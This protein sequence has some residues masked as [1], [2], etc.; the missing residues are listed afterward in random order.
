MKTLSLFYLCAICLH[1]GSGYVIAFVQNC[2]ALP[3]PGPWAFN[4]NITILPEAWSKLYVMRGD[5]I[6]QSGK[7]YAEIINSG[8]GLIAKHHFEKEKIGTMDF[9]NPWPLFLN[10]P[11]PEGQPVFSDFRNTFDLTNHLAPEKMFG[12]TT[13]LIVPKFSNTPPTVM[14]L[15]QIYG[16]YLGTN[17]YKVDENHCWILLKRI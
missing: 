5:A 8:I 14:A 9:V 7:S 12:H 2:G 4:P 10:A 3:N 11:W 16:P 13:I 6:L 1:M 15:E 17:F